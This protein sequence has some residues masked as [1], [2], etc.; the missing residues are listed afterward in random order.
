MLHSF[1]NKKYWHV[2]DI[3]IWNFNEI[4]TNDFVSFERLQCLPRFFIFQSEPVYV[5]RS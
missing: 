3:N 2:S 1:F 5:N 4:L